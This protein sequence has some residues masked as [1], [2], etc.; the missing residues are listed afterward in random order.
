MAAGC[1]RITKR[2]Q[3]SSGLPAHFDLMRVAR[4]RRDI[5]SVAMADPDDRPATGLTVPSAMP[6]EASDPFWDRGRPARSSSKCGRDARGPR[7][8][9]KRVAT[10]SDSS[11]R[12]AKLDWYERVALSRRKR[13]IR[14]FDAARR[15]A[16]RRRRPYKV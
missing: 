11:A 2:K 4:A 16:A 6:G 14:A 8:A 1:G 7:D 9:D 12:L 15:K 13:A 5:I 3:W 10:L